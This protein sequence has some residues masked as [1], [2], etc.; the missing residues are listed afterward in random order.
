[1]VCSDEWRR[2]LGASSMG[3]SGRVAEAATARRAGFRSLL[4]LDV[5][6]EK[7]L[8]ARIGGVVDLKLYAPRGQHHWGA[9]CVHGAEERVV[10]GVCQGG[11]HVDL[12]L[13]EPG[14]VGDPH[15]AVLQGMH[16]LG[17]GDGLGVDATVLDDGVVF[18]AG[19]WK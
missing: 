10:T 3:L 12:L 8:D 5:L 19:R 17:G 1:M 18:A 14:S 13:V 16:G 6:D 4:T 11:E 9:Q 7:R 15:R 2:R